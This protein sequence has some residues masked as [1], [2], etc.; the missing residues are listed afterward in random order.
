MLGDFNRPDLKASSNNV[1]EFMCCMATIDFFQIVIGSTHIGDHAC[2]VVSEWRLDDP[3]K[4][5]VMTKSHADC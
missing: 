3:W 2:N 5:F 4:S 1:Q